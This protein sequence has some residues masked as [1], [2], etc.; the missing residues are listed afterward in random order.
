M[1][2][3]DTIAK[4]VNCKFSGQEGRDERIETTGREKY[5]GVNALRLANSRR[6][7]YRGISCVCG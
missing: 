1:L 4:K 3:Y 5:G 2:V 7:E 6:C